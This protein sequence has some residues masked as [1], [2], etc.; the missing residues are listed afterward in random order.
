[1]AGPIEGIASYDFEG[2]FSI[3]IGLFIVFELGCISFLSSV[4]LLLSSILQIVRSYRQYG[5]ALPDKSFVQPTSILFLSLLLADSCQAL[6]SVLSLRWSID[7]RV[8]SGAYCVAQGVLTHI[9]DIGSALI[10]SI[11]TVA[12]IVSMTCPSTFKE[13]VKRAV[14][15]ALG[16]AI[17]LILCLLIGVPSATIS[18]F[19]D[20]TGLWCW[21]SDRKP[22][23]RGLQIGGDTAWIWVGMAVCVLCCLCALVIRPKTDAIIMDEDRH[24]NRAT[25]LFPGAYATLVLPTVI[26]RA[27]DHSTV[28]STRGPVVSHG[29]TIFAQ[30]IL[31]LSGVINVILWL[32]FGR[33]FNLTS[34]PALSHPD[35]FAS[36]SRLR[37]TATDMTIDI[38]Q[39]MH[40]FPPQDPQLGVREYGSTE[41]DPY[42]IPARIS[43]M[44]V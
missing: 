30:C 24:S 13:R 16:P 42:N 15:Y 3:R 21:I 8:Q 14:C 17:I 2:K 22:V 25:L 27:I 4:W 23:T 35:T 33:Q 34:N 11:I 12:M 18:N 41:W 37:P 5:G 43:T 26:V 44:N 7:A 10:T 40:A 20:N 19:Y 1:M 38:S 6:G 29:W 36:R 28:S 9:G 31:A 32:S 39:Q